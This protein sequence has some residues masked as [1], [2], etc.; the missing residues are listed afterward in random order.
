[1][2][3][4][5]R[6]QAI[7]DLTLWVALALLVTALVIFIQ[8]CEFLTPYDAPDDWAYH[9]P[10]E[11]ITD[12]IPEDTI[13]VDTLPTD[14]IVVVSDTCDEFIEFT[15]PEFV[16]GFMIIDETVTTPVVIHVGQYTD[17]I[18]PGEDMSDKLTNLLYLYDSNNSYQVWVSDNDWRRIAFIAKG[19]N[20][21]EHFHG[22]TYL[23]FNGYQTGWGFPCS[24]QAFDF[25]GSLNF[26]EYFDVIHE[27]PSVNRFNF[28]AT[29]Y[30]SIQYVKLSQEILKGCKAGR[31]KADFRF[32]PYP[33]ADTIIT[34]FEERNWD[35]ILH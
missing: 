30:D 1:M 23:R 27:Y 12:T 4:I 29:N 3:N 5:F 14:T 33:I 7:A 17:T 21:H 32:L 28:I 20:D 26:D 9:P 11:E 8:G 16:S 24:I 2:K 19:T 13:V 18:Q 15:Q 10:A 22:E 25:Q 35:V 6:N 34:L 31:Y